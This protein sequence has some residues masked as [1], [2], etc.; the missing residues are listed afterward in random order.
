VV[1]SFCIT[2]YF[3]SVFVQP[4]FFGPGLPEENIWSCPADIEK[5]PKEINKMHLVD[6][7]A[8][9]SRTSC[10]ILSHHLYLQPLRNLQQLGIRLR[11]KEMYR[12]V[13]ANFSQLFLQNLLLFVSFN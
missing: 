10:G 5:M 12:N 6:L 7:S 13:T 11:H 1:Y 4:A 8:L 9:V 3:L 2:E